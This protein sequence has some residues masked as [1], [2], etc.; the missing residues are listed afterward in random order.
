MP[1]RGTPL[2]L[3]SVIVTTWY[4]LTDLLVRDVSLVGGFKSPLL[5]WLGSAGLGLFFAWQVAKLYREA[6]RAGAPLRDLDPLLTSLAEDAGTAELRGASKRARTDGR[7]PRTESDESARAADRLAELDQAMREDDAVR[8][9]WTQFRKT[10]LI[11]H[12]PWFKEPR[13]FSTRRAEEFFTHEAVLG[14]AV[15][16]GFYAQVPSLLTGIGLLLT[17]VALCT[18]LSRLHADGHT[19]TGIQGLING[20][21]GK[22]LTSI[23]A[24]IGANLFVVLERP[25]VRRLTAEHRA[26]VALVDELFPRRTMED[27]LDALGRH[28]PLRESAP[29]DGRADVEPMGHALPD[30]L[31]PQLRELTAAVRGLAERGQEPREALRLFTSAVTSL[32]ESQER[33]HAQLAAALDRLALSPAPARPVLEPVGREGVRSRGRRLG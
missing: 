33:A 2:E 15:D 17:F 6:A 7:D 16:L 18:G 22:F 5:S 28:R 8:G 4:A 29:R 25:V 12:V 13:I 21:A 30:T 24:L 11:E 23:V 9:P 31:G 27:L 32:E 26:F 10:L 20:L 1:T 19:I 3:S 14:R